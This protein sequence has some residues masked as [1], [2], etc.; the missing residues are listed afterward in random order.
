MIK[1]PIEIC[2][3]RCDEKLTATLKSDKFGI[4][5]LLSDDL[6][7]DDELLLSMPITLQSFVLE[8]EKAAKAKGDYGLDDCVKCG[9]DEDDCKCDETIYRDECIKCASIESLGERCRCKNGPT[10]YLDDKGSKVDG[11][12]IS[13][14]ITLCPTH[15]PSKKKLARIKAKKQ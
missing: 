6:L 2:C 11:W 13:D 7:K 12:Y 14:G 1:M 10:Y 4:T 3:D 9:E 15:K 5:E 8:I